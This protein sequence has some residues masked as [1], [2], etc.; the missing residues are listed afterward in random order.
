MQQ[1]GF[2]SYDAASVDEDPV[3]RWIGREVKRFLVEA[4]I[5]LP[6]LLQLASAP[7]DLVPDSV[8]KYMN[9]AGEEEMDLEGDEFAPT[10][11]EIERERNEVPT[12]I[13]HAEMWD[14]FR[15]WVRCVQEPWTRDDD[16]YRDAG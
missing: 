11:E 7:L 15:A 16:E 3:K 13:A 9:A 2:Y 8:Q 1:A 5:H 10:D 14:R 12:M 6:F 4:H